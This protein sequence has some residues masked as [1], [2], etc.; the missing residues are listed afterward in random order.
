MT[1]PLIADYDAALFDLDGVL[2]LGPQ[3]VPGATEA[4][5]AL[6]A[7]G[8]RIGFVTNNASRTPQDI[9]THLGRLGM[10][11]APSE[12]VVSSQAL[13]R[14]MA[15]A[16]PTGSVVL[17][18]GPPALAHELADAGFTIVERRA[19]G[20]AAVVQGYHP[21]LP[22]SMINEAALALGDGAAWYASNTDT[23]RPTDIGEVPGAGAQIAILRACFPEREPIVAGKPYP[24]MFSEMMTRLDVRHPVF[25]GDRLD[26]DISGAVRAGLDSLLVLSGAHRKADLVGADASCRPTHLGWD[27]GALLAPARRISALAD[28]S[29]WRCGEATAQ[30]TSAADVDL[31]G[32]LDAVEGQ[33]DCLW[34]LA[35]LAWHGADRG[36]PLDVS[37]ALAR[38]DQ[39]P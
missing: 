28:G 38:L 4:L 30:K 13:A 14:L 15:G 19:D 24:P 32:A 27:V 29:G 10:A 11:C 16:L 37:E 7:Q 39:I 2:I 34:A 23:L 22:W 3:A 6:R 20:P 17:V 18:A 31:Q 21:D 33:L 12:V 25:V 36:E 35:H 5:S 26:T 8:A 9:A 1:T